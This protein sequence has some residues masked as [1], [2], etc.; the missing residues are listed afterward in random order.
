M[1]CLATLAVVFLVSAPVAA[2]QPPA[3]SPSKTASS[4][5]GTILPGTYDLDIAFGGGALKGSMLLTTVGDSLTATLH[6]GEHSPAVRSLTR[7]GS[8]LVLNAGDDGMK[9][10]YDFQFRGD[11]VSGTFTFNADE[12]LVSG[13][14]RR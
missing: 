14:R 11:S 8:R 9:L 10:V 6:V 4:S 7:K 2:A 12:G 5:S 3:T 1:R 13:K